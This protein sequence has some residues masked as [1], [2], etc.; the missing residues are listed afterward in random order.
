VVPA[1]LVISCLGSL[2]DL[3]FTGARSSNLKHYLTTSCNMTE[4]HKENAVGLVKT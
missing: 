1:I 2:S 3:V 4:T